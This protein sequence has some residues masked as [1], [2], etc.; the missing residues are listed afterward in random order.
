MNR[1]SR[2]FL[3]EIAP[4]VR[5]ERLLRVRSSRNDLAALRSSPHC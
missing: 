2:I 1:Q 3:E 4:V 5:D